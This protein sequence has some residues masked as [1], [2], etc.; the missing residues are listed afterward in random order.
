MQTMN[1]IIILLVFISQTI[2]LFAQPVDEPTFINENAYS[3]PFLHFV[4]DEKHF[5]KYAIEA[6]SGSFELMEQFKGKLHI[7]TGIN[8]IWQDVENSNLHTKGEYDYSKDFRVG[9]R[10][11]FYIG[12][13][14]VS[15][16]LKN[17]EKPQQDTS[18]FTFYF[19][20]DPL[21]FEQGEGDINFAYI[22]FLKNLKKKGSHLVIEAAL[23]SKNL[24]HISYV[25]IACGSFYLRYDDIKYGEW[26]ESAT[27]YNIQLK[28]LA[29]STMK[30][31]FGEIGFSKNFTMS[32]LQNPCAK[33]YQYDNTLV[34]NNPCASEP[35]DSCKEAIATYNFVKKD[36]PLTIKILITIKENGNFVNIEN[37]QFG[38]NEITIEKQNLLS[39]TE[40]Q[41]I[42]YNKFHKESVEILPFGN[43]LRYSNTPIKQ[44]E[45]KDEDNKLNKDPGYRLLKETKAGKNWE[46]GFVY[47][48]RSNNPKMLNRVYHFDA[49]TGKLLW[50]TEFY[51][52]TS[53]KHSH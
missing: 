27:D 25:P 28:Q 4:S 5:A 29:D 42:I 22:E 38:K 50:I 37:N 30:S 13:V 1:K 20:L 46:N 16:A 26:K 39:I 45:Y 43:A 9:I 15:T 44:P 53:E 8:K 48:A 19:E 34:S 40:I 23:P 11:N 52:V 7:P 36:V 41:K 6:H 10:F 12:G 31:I 47:L 18:S 51:N 24:N 2:N 49:V 33:G 17:F 14:L 32:C 21:D 3:Q 35:Q